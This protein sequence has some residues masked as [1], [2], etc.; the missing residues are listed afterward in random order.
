MKLKLK[1]FLIC[2]KKYFQHLLIILISSLLLILSFK[3]LNTFDIFYIYLVVTNLVLIIYL[4]FFKIVNK[5]WVRFKN[6]IK[7]NRSNH[8]IIISPFVFIFFVILLGFK[9]NTLLLYIQGLIRLNDITIDFPI[10]K[11]TIIIPEKRINLFEKQI[12]RRTFDL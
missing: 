7:L 8:I 11:A 2:I 6:T 4:C 3:Y 5:F 9:L 12:E 1:N 10:T